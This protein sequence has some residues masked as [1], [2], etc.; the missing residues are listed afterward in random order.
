MKPFNLQISD[1]ARADLEKQASAI[2]APS[3]NAWAAI[4]VGVVSA[5]PP[6]KVLLLLG[7]AKEIQ[8]EPKKRVSEL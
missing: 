2:G 8:A 1:E 4:I 3:A 5:L 7:K 6:A